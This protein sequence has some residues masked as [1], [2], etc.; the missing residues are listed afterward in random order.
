MAEFTIFPIHRRKHY[1]LDAARMILTERPGKWEIKYNEK[2]TAAKKLWNT[3]L[4]PYKPQIHHLNE[5]ETVLVFEVKLKE[6][7]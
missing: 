7:I 4:A 3:V 6:K 1:A 2:N 5:V